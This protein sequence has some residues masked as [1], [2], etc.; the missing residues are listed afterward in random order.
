LNFQP[1]AVVA[2]YF[3]AEI[4]WAIVAI[5]ADSDRGQQ[6]DKVADWQ[7]FALHLQ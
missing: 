7:W 1:F 2:I 5:D 4:L 6:L 3:G